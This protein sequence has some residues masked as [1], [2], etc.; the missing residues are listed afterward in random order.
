MPILDVEIVLQPDEMLAATLATDL[1]DRAAIVFRSRP[2]QTWVRLRPIPHQHYA[3]NGSAPADVFP[4]FVSV[5]KA[6]P[7]VGENLD[8]EIQ[9]LTAT[10]AE[11][12]GRA[13]E[14]VHLIY[15]PA[16]AGRVAFGGRLVQ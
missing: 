2:Q 16:A 6:H 1:A 15:A 3:E 7:P 4:V 11:A 8:R 9:A 13:P 14:R 10:V 12:C 5:L